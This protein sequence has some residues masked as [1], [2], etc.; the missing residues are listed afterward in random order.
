M[1]VD[2]V[3]DLLS[4][5]GLGTV[6]TS[7][8]KGSMYGTADPSLAVLAVGGQPSVHA[9]QASAGSAAVE[10]PR[11]QIVA[12]SLD[13]EQAFKTAQAAFRVLDGLRERTING[14]RYL[15]AEAVQPPFGLD[16]D[17]NNRF[18]VVFNV[19]LQREHST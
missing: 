3:A 18:C 13:E 19:D 10:R 7:I 11:V 9:M 17:D 14:I 2:D 4:T 15:W 12:R 6:G 5:S 16:R 1:L 8:W